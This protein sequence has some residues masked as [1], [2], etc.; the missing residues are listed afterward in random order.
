[1][2]Q[3]VVEVA[4]PPPHHISLHGYPIPSHHAAA[5]HQG[6][7]PFGRRAVVGYVLGTTTES[8]EGLTLRPIKRIVDDTEPTFDEP[9]LTFLRWMATYYH[10]PLGETL[11]GAHPAGTNMK[12]I[13]G[14][15]SGPSPLLADAAAETD[16]NLSS[17]LYALRNH[18]GPVAIRELP[19]SPSDAELRTW[20]EQGFI[21]RAPVRVKARVDA[22]R[23]EAT[24]PL[25]LPRPSREAEVERI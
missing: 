18:E 11:R 20:I 10:A 6:Q 12:S 16:P 13:P 14:V 21:E 3:T 17:V 23:V 7:V 1:M 8:P 4:I 15:K 19:A 5:W 9:M 25:R 2:T 22:R 24:A